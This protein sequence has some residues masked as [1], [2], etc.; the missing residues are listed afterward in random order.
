MS[1]ATMKP[2]R[3]RLSVLALI[4]AATL[5]NYLDRSVM[6]VA[7]PELVKDLHI[8]PAVMG[9]IFSA[10]SWTYALAQI[11][12]GYVIDKLGTRLTYGPLI[13]ARAR[14]N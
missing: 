9:L 5:I 8:S 6:G 3:A 14:R 11:P 10:F 2:S 1:G 7:K 13:P 12:G 4:S